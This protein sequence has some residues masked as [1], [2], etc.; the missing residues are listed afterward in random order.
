MVINN[1]MEKGIVALPIHDSF[2]VIDGEEEALID[3]M[4]KC[5]LDMF[6]FKPE[7]D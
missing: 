4:N 1:L 5:Y 7:I 2:I 3:E 6:G